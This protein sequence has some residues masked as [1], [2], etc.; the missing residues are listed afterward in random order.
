LERDEIRRELYK[1]SRLEALIILLSDNKKI[2]PK[3]DLSNGYT[4]P[5]LD[6]IMPENAGENKDDFLKRVVT[7]KVLDKELFD[8]EFRCPKCKS[9]DFSTRYLCP[10]CESMTIIKNLLVEHINCGQTSTKSNLR[11][12]SWF[13]FCP[14]CNKKY[15]EGGYRI[16]GKWFECSNCDKQVKN[17]MIAHFC[18]NC[19]NIFSFD[20]AIQREVYSYSLNSEAKKEIEAAVIFPSEIKR[21][22]TNAN[23]KIK[24]SN[25][26]N[27][28]SGIE[29]KFDY[30]A[31]NNKKTIAVDTI[32]SSQ[33]IPEIEIV[34]EQSKFYDTGI[35]IYVIVTPK[36]IEQASMIA[37]ASQLK[38]VEASNKKDALLGL[39]K[40]LL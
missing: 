39:R 22:L 35:E 9:P 34:K 8:I 6:K 29:Q 7:A 36:L 31:S 21:I 14:N 18:R 4:Y 13:D 16:V 23:Y 2:E 17:P 32:F 25:V 10:F 15:S 37:K 19:H 1:D 3:F 30:V 24:A 12:E 40:S 28:K 20:D 33:P 38:I 26:I 11:E 27:G 5:D